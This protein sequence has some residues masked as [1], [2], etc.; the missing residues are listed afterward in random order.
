[1]ATE[2]APIT[3]MGCLQETGSDF[4]LTALNTPASDSSGAVG[5]S[6]AA[7]DARP[8]GTSGTDA[9]GMAGSESP[10]ADQMSAARQ[11]YRLDGDDDSLRAHV[12]AQV[13]VMGTLEE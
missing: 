7:S 8:A 3:L 13:R 5:T 12:G 2:S 10:R 4:V 1:P 9:P 11:S 6:G